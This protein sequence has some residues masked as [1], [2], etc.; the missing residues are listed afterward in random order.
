MM[1]DMVAVDNETVG[2]A[3]RK[4]QDRCGIAKKTPTRRRTPPVTLDFAD[5]Q[6]CCGMRWRRRGPRRKPLATTKDPDLLPQVDPGVSCPSP[7]PQAPRSKIFRRLSIVLPSLPKIAVDA[8]PG[9]FYTM[10]SVALTA[11]PLNRA[12]PAACSSSGKDSRS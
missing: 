11:T 7:V 6:R 3:G 2:E 10:I 1:C 5:Q 9:S 12:R 8:A 4:R